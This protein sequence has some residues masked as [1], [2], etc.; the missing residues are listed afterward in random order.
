MSKINKVIDAWFEKDHFIG[1]RHPA[2][3]KFKQ[4]LDKVIGENYCSNEQMMELLKEHERYWDVKWKRKIEKEIIQEA[5][6]L[7]K[8]EK[9]AGEFRRAIIYNRD[10]FIKCLIG[11]EEVK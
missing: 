4:A 6:K 8:E 5:E 7:L 2:T 1:K 9:G 11:E 3:E 10:C